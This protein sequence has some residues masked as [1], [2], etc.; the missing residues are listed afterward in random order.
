[1]AENK[2]TMQ[3]LVGIPPP[4]PEIFEFQLPAGRATDLTKRNV[5]EQGGWYFPGKTEYIAGKGC[6]EW[7]REYDGHPAPP[8]PAVRIPFWDTIQALAPLKRILLITVKLL[9]SKEFRPLLFFT[10][11]IGKKSRG[12]LLERACS[13]FNDL[14][15]GVIA[16]KYLKF[17]YYSPPVREIIGFVTRLLASLGVK[18]EVADRTAKTIGMFFENDQAY[19]WRFVDA[20]AYT[21]KRDLEDDFYGEME[22]LFRI[23]ESHDPN[24]EGMRDRGL[25]ALKA[26]KA[27]LWFPSVRDAV[28]EAVD[29][30]DVEACK[31]TEN[32]IYHTILYGDY[33]MQG[34]NW[35]ERQELYRKYHGDDPDKWPAR[36]QLQ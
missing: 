27:A 23:V 16:Y 6:F 35:E 21:T 26:L 24:G 5:Q 10:V 29:G 22:R 3:E 28:R 19:C 34:R 32:D 12:K 36:W 17:E 15:M 13:L 18:V 2:K 4:P 11:F 14:A 20:M 7:F 30:L 31:P 8:L 25:P 33:N 1:M 9:G